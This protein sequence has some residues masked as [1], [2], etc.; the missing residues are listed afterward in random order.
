MSHSKQKESVTEVGTN[1]L[2]KSKQQRWVTDQWFVCGV[3]GEG[4]VAEHFI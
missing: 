1:I 3:V 4:L 2:E